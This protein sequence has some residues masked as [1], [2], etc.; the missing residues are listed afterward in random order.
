MWS[1]IITMIIATATLAVTWSGI[2]Y[3]GSDSEQYIELAEGHPE[4][5][6]K[7]FSGRILYPTLVRGFKTI[8]LSTDGG[9]LVAALLALIMLP[10]ALSLR[11]T[12]EVQHWFMLLPVLL[13]PF[14]MQMFRECYLPDLFHAA[15]LGLFFAVFERARLASLLV[16]LMLILTRESTIL[17]GASII[18]LALYRSDRRLALKI[19]LTT[20]VGLAAVRYAGSFGRPNIHEMNDLIYMVLKVPFNL[21]LNVTGIQLWANTLDYCT[22]QITFSVAGWLPLGSIKTMGVC[23]LNL[24]RPLSTAALMLTTFGVAPTLLLFHLTKNPR[25]FFKEKPFW[26]AVALLYGISSFFLGVALGSSVYRLIGYGWPAFWLTMPMILARH[27]DTDRGTFFLLVF[28][29]VVTSWL[30][31]IIGLLHLNPSSAMLTMI[32][33]ALTMHSLCLKTIWAKAI[34]ADQ[35]SLFQTP[36][37]RGQI[38]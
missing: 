8:G 37:P 9:F 36:E 19:C 1:T 6:I 28:C 34:G 25:Q 27:Y 7:P 3:H 16:F 15:L 26:L 31:F 17:L 33:L 2:P 22:P 38:S 32:A 10:F 11:V 20:I 14:L 30:T 35:L 5:T 13:S 18:F 12:K 23:E 21:I 4:N 29:H 24:M